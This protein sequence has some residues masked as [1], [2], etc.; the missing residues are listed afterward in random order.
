MGQTAGKCCYGPW[1]LECDVGSDCEW[2]CLE[3][4]WL[5]CDTGA[6]CD[7]L[8][9]SCTKCKTDFA[10]CCVDTDYGI[11]ETAC[12]E[13]QACN[14]R[15]KNDPEMGETCD[16]PQGW[17][18]SCLEDGCEKQSRPST[19]GREYEHGGPEKQA[20]K[21]QCVKDGG[22]WGNSESGGGGTWTCYFDEGV[23]YDVGATNVD[24][25]YNCWKKA[26]A[27]NGRA[28]EVITDS[29]S[30]PFVPVGVIDDFPF[31]DAQATWQHTE[32]LNGCY[33]NQAAGSDGEQCKNLNGYCIEKDG[34]TSTWFRD[35]ATKGGCE[36]L[37]DPNKP[38]PDKEYRWEDKGLYGSPHGDK[39]RKEFLDPSY[40]DKDFCN[41]VLGTAIG[42][43][44]DLEGVSYTPGRF[45]S[46]A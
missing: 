7:H 26:Y 2:K 42:N 46:E 33:W 12:L 31:P 20:D 10:E 28:S 16:D 24:T 29:C 9:P 27:I 17:C 30:T 39:C 38:N 15:S 13:A 32:C 45:K 22:R 1:E 41:A 19:C 34:D 4:A 35:S 36:G 40:L 23:H 6:A 44:T 3:E 14:D 8:V 18:G 43:G 5:V 21:D 37:N 25:A 11:N